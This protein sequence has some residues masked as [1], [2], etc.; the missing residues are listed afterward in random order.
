MWKI[1]DIFADQLFSFAY[2]KSSG[3]GFEENEYDRLMGLWTDVSYLRQYAKDNGITDINQ[4]TI[5]KL[6]DAEEIQDI[7]DEITQEGKSLSDYFQPLTDSE[8]MKELSKRKGKVK[9]N[10]LRLYAI[11][12]DDDCF[13]ITG[14]AIKMSQA[15]QDHP[16]TDKELSK[17]KRAVDYLKEEGVLDKASFFEL[18]SET[19]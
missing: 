14:G 6:R 12:I 4:F 7:L 11:K 17:I 9:R 2:P 16:D 19:S 10:G 15:M 8:A 13:V 3:E 5:D 18:K 1:V